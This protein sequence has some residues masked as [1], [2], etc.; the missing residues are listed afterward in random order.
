[1]MAQ[2]TAFEIRPFSPDQL[3]PLLALFNE[4]IRGRRSAAAVTTDDFRQ[5]VLEHPGFDPSG[6]L[7][8]SQGHG[9]ILG[10]V[11][12]IAPPVQIAHYARLAGQGFIFGPYVYGRSRG[13][14]IG[15]TLLAEAERWLSFHSEAAL[16]HGLRSPFYHTQEG[17]RQ[18]YCGSTE[19]M[20]LTHDDHALLSFLQHAG[21]QPI[22]EREVSM[23]A[24]LHPVEMPERAPDSLRLVRASPHN[25]W[26]G[27]VA[28]A[29]GETS[30]YGY[31]RYHPMADYDTFA[32][33]Q[34]DAIVGHCQWY[35]MR[36]AGRAVLFD[37]RVDPA[38]RGQGIGRLVLRGALAA[39][40]RSGYRE[41]ELHT[42]PQRN[43]V[44]YSMYLHF[45]FREVAEWVML[46]KALR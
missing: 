34:G 19:V 35:P 6:L 24:L 27:T 46:R 9:Q 38:F 12:A 20:G 7:I 31:D 29:P 3:E 4:A 16:I 45:G 32:V 30:G 13:L 11:H 37:L 8:A 2:S 25:P 40:A 18:P 28:W 44:A 14:G 33:A 10:A 1:M 42:S 26:R 5:R 36:R 39:M 41:V 22:V 15:R 17:P 21:Y 43:S 23:S